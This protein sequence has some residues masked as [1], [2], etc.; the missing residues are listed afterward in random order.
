MDVGSPGFL[1]LNLGWPY[2]PTRQFTADERDGELLLFL[3]TLK[4]DLY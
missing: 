3:D 2:P 1:K 4:S